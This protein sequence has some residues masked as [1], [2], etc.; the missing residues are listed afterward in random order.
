MDVLYGIQVK[1]KHCYCDKELLINKYVTYILLPLTV[2]RQKQIAYDY[3][4]STN[5]SLNLAKMIKVIYFFWHSL[6]TPTWQ[7]WT[8]NIITQTQKNYKCTKD[9]M[10]RTLVCF[11]VS[12]RLG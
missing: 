12:L 9:R 5:F 10:P 4:V 1:Y 3:K 7:T 6:E 2:L 8:M 11:I